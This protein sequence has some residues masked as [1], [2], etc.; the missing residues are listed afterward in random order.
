MSDAR[1]RIR[2]LLMLAQHPGTPQAEA[3]SALAMASKLMQKHG[4]DDSDLDGG[5]PDG[6]FVDDV[7]VVVERVVVSGRYRLRRMNLLY[8]IGLVHSCV[9]YRDGDADDG[10]CV[11]VMYGRR[12]DILASRTLW[13]AADA[14]AARL[15]PRGDRSSRTAWFKGYQ[16]GIEEVLNTARTEHIAET[17]G[18]GIVLADRFSRARAEMRASGVRLRSGMSWV[19]SSSNAWRDGRSAGRGFGASGRSFTSGVYGEIE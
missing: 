11:L 8:A 18:A 5:A 6:N 15:L 17:A 4:L 13:T 3:E 12:S 10:S 14:M 19:D 16:A 9:G 7:E 1:T 2:A